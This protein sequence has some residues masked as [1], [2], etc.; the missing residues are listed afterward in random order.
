MNEKIIRISKSIA[1][2]SLSL[3]FLLAPL[4]FLP[5]TTDFFQF[6]KFVFFTLLTF[7]ALIA[8]LVYNLATKNIRLTISPLLLPLFL[9]AVVGVGSTLLNTPQNPQAWTGRTAL[10][11]I[12]FIF[13]LLTT[14]LINSSN[15]V[16]RILNALII[17]SVALAFQGILSIMGVFASLGLPS[18]LTSKLFSPTGSPLNLVTF[19]FSVLPICL[20]LALKTKTGP[21][22]IGYFLASGFLISSLILIGYQLLPKQ[23]LSPLMLNQLSGWSIAIDTIKTKPFLGA[24]PDEFLNQFTQFKPIALNQT[25]LWNINFT[26]SSSEYLNILTTLGFAGLAVFLLIGYTFFKLIKRDPGTRTTTTQMAVNLATVALLVLGLFIPF[27]YLHWFVLAGYLSLSVG[28]NKSKN[29]TKVKDVILTINAITVVEPYE[30]TPVP[31]A[32]TTTA[33]FP[34]LVAVPA[35]IALVFSSY[36]IGRLYAAEQTFNNS[37]ISAN[38]NKGMETYNQQIK[39]IQ[40]S[41]NID[42][43]HL[44]YSTTNLA[45]ASSLSAKPELTDQERQTITQLVQQAVSEA[46]TATQLQPNKTAVWS[47]LANVYRQLINFA[48][49]AQDF[50]LAAYIRAVQLDPANPQLRLELGGLM[51]S[52][53]RYD[54]AVA[55]FQEAIQLKSDYANA[56]YNLSHAFLEQKKFL[57]AYQTMQ[58]VL[59]LVPADSAELTQIQQELADL[60]TKL[61]AAT[62]PPAAGQETTSQLTQPSPPPPAP[63]GFEPVDLQASPTPEPTPNP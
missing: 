3:A 52:L 29:L 22:K 13:F 40:L 54:E 17:I 55:R 6:N 15:T 28:L 32:S 14:T 45:L 37:L 58:S 25:R 44:A 35:L 60:K 12:I 5:F 39:A 62:P 57:E 30:I 47:N 42:R 20:V 49:G 18:Y 43:Y 2:I 1:L 48:D 61:P 36:K 4:F 59:A 46:R 24:G 21:K 38:A 23:P 51:F 63:E 8:W 33:L 53:K 26:N 31:S 56:H 9:L 50:S 16:K 34:I 19:L 41:P 10:Y 11:I 7:V 27:T